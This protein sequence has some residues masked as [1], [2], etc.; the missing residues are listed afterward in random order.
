VGFS[1]PG[2]LDHLAEGGFFVERLQV[3]PGPQVVVVRPEL[4]GGG[5][6]ASFGRWGLHWLGGSFLA[7]HEKGEERQETLDVRKEIRDLFSGTCPTLLLRYFNEISVAYA[8]GSL[9]SRKGYLAR[10]RKTNNLQLLNKPVI[11]GIKD[12]SIVKP[13]A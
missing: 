5:P 1:V 7:Q 11:N 8:S 6:V 4:V 13:V 3:L 9:I 2:A 10:H 12:R